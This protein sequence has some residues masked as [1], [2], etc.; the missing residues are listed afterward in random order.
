MLTLINQ[1]TKKNKDRSVWDKTFEHTGIKRDKKL[2]QL[3][4]WWNWFFYCICKCPASYKNHDTDF[5]MVK[6]CMTWNTTLVI[7]GQE[8]PKESF[9]GRW[10][11]LTVPHSWAALSVH[12]ISGTPF[13]SVT[14]SQE[15]ELNSY[16]HG[17]A[18][19]QNLSMNHL[20]TS[21]RWA[22]TE[23]NHSCFQIFFI[24]LN[25]VVHVQRLTGKYF[26][27][28]FPASSK[29]PYGCCTLPLQP[30]LNE[31]DPISLKRRSY[32]LSNLIP[33]HVL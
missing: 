3:K 2:R 27:L 12:S 33:G 23:Q 11:H 22:I 1:V 4:W 7:K 28:F 16:S 26:T 15:V 17:T 5:L 21:S 31:Q 24:H 19:A 8:K 9:P 18:L 13:C 10:Q 32:P 6:K 20:Q 14:K 29:T 30:E 25:W